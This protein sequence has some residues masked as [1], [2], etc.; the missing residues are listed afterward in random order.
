MKILQTGEYKV[1]HVL[2]ALVKLW[3]VCRS[4]DSGAEIML[5]YVCEAQG[6]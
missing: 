3:F 2:G 5:I 1:G 6:V 4:W